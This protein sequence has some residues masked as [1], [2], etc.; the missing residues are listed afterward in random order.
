MRVFF[1]APPN[2]NPDLPIGR[3]KV[4]ANHNDGMRVV[5]D[6]PLAKSG[7]I[8]RLPS[9]FLSEYWQFEFTGYVRIWSAQVASTV[10]ELTRV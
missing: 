10:K 5:L 7:D 9:G 4:W 6:R 3:I 1:V 8:L 2:L